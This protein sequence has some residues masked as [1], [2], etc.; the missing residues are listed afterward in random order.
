MGDLEK[1]ARDLF[2]EHAQKR[3]P[4]MTDSNPHQMSTTTEGGRENPCPS[5][6]LLPPKALVRIA[7]IMEVGAKTH[8]DPDGTNWRKIPIRRLLDHVI[9]HIYLYLAGDVT[10]DHLGNAATRMLMALEQAK[11]GGCDKIYLEGGR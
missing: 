10:E 4:E 2:L 5:F 3:A 6:S 8:S 7:E 11:D 9:S 1:I